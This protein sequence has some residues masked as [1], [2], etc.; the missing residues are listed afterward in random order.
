[1]VPSVVVMT[2]YGVINEDKVDILVIILLAIQSYVTSGR[3]YWVCKA[4]TH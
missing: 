1:M 2:I 4:T 3:I